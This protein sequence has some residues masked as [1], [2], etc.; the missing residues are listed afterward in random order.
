M[1]YNEKARTNYFKV[2]DMDALEHFCKLSQAKL[3]AQSGDD[4][5]IRQRWNDD[6]G[7]L[8]AIIAEEGIP[9]TGFDEELEDDVEIDFCDALC[10]FL[11]DGEIL[12]LKGNGYEGMDHITGWATAYDNTGKMV[13][14]NIDDIY[15]KAAKAFDVKEND[16]N[17]A[18]Y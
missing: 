4:S 7:L 17:R 13:T 10:D 9:P 14:I 18:N 16:I 6:K 3:S 5:S 2:K 15:A 1:N 12:I 8:V 11:A